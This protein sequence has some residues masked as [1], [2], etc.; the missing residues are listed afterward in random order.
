MTG[1]FLENL[2]M[3][4]AVSNFYLALAETMLFLFFHGKNR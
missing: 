3:F 1:P 2:N 4:A